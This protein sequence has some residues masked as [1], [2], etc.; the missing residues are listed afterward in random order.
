MKEK[1]KKE[2]IHNDLAENKSRINQIQGVEGKIS[3][4]SAKKKKSSPT[5]LKAPILS[6]TEQVP[7]NLRILVADDD[8]TILD[9]FRQV[10]S[11]AKTNPIVGSD[12]QE[13]GGKHPNY[14]PSLS[15]DIVTCRQ[16]DEAVDAVK[17]SIKENRHF[18]VAFIDVRMP[19][20]PDGIW[21]AEKIRTF[22][23]QIEIVIFTG[24]S[25][26]HPGI[27][28]RRVPPVHKL[29]YLQK[30]FHP[31][32][33]YQFASALSM[34]WHAECELQRLNKRL[35]KSVEERIEEFIKVNEE[36]QIKLIEHQ[37]LNKA[38]SESEN[39][40]KEFL[41]NL[42]DIA[43]EANS[44]GDITYANKTA[45]ILT[46]KP[47]KD[48]IGKSFFSLFTEEGQVKAMDEFQKTLKGE[49]T[50]FD[51]TFATGRICN[52]KN[53][54]LKS[55]GGQIIGVFGIA[56]DITDLKHAENELRKAHDELEH[57]VIE[58]TLKLNT[59]LKTIKRSE[60]ELTQRK[61]A[62]ER[63]NRELV[64]TNQA[65]S[66]L[67]RNI[68]RDKDLLERN[69][70][71]IISTNI[72]PILKELEDDIGCRKRLADLELLKTYLY[73]LISDPTDYHEI[74]VCLS[75]QEMR[76]AAMI[77]RGLT[78]Q[79]IADMLN[80]SLDTVKFHR[81]NIRKKLK[82]QNSNIN[83]TSY[84]KSKFIE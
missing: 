22:D 72:M 69:F 45:E 28:T 39:R 25:D 20:G 84:L 62:L 79:K 26:T 68:D 46:G 32:E 34:K 33:I 36:L 47:L 37:E 60:K 58:R 24:Y 10:F 40:F 21:T 63:L 48:I 59:A 12:A 54:P 35:E 3:S 82:L 8:T 71:E 4:G 42:G 75:T 19:P 23:S 7:Q 49:R 77:K 38:L 16:G 57:L 11:P 76:V 80:I 30:P 74:V 14:Q 27:I 56:R 2:I 44:Y 1:S 52:F 65:L 66:A 78:S 43:Y 13:S 15:F 41:E 70:Y 81:K 50:Q 73:S 64:E 17:S 18:S 51:L 55:T 29:I 83:L 5:R 9:L 61:F 31:L 6:T 53:E 67:A